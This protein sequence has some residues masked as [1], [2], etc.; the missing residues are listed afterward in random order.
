MNKKDVPA[1]VGTRPGGIDWVMWGGRRVAVR[2]VLCWWDEP[3]APWVGTTERHY[4]RLL[5]A[6]GGVLEVCHEAGRWMVCGV[7]D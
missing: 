4:A 5:L 1:R 7:E 2:D 3:A 6:T